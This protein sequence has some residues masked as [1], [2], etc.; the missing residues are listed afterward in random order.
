M[1]AL[2]KEGEKKEKFLQ[3]GVFVFG[4]HPSTI[5]AEQ[6]LSLVSK[7]N[8]LL[9]LWYSDSKVKIYRKEKKISDTAW[10]GK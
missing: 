6:G 3:H 5:H 2:E 9:S 10:L 7:P 4:H 8:M 1:I